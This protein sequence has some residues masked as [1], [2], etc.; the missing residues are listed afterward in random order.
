VTLEERQAAMKYRTAR[1]SR[2]RAAKLRAKIIQLAHRYPLLSYE[3][4]GRRAGDYTAI[5]SSTR[6]SAT[7]NPKLDGYAYLGGPL[8]RLMP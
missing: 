2:G 8:Y 4:I 3:E 6:V 5:Y 7:G 1:A